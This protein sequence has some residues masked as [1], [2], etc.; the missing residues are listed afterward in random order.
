MLEFFRKLFVSDFMPHGH[1]YFW[2]PYLVWLNTTSDALVGLSYFLIPF[3]LYQIVRKRRDLTFNWMILMFVG[4]ILA[5]GFTHV[6]NVWDVWHSAYRLEGLVKA[7]TAAA[8]LATAMLMFRLV[9]QLVAIP[10]S[11]QLRHEIDDRKKA[12]SEVRTLNYELERRVADRTAM[13]QR[14]NDA[15]QRFAYIVS[16]DLQEPVRTIRTMNQLLVRDYAGKLDG[17]ADKYISFV[18]DASARMQTLISDLLEYACLMPEMEVGEIHSTDSKAIFEAVVRNLSQ[19]IAECSAEVRC[20]ELPQLAVEPVHLTQV[21]QNLLSNSIKYRGAQK[22]LIQVS[23]ETR[24][25]E[26]LFTFRDNGIGFDP[27][28]SEQIF[29]AFR[30]L[31]GREFPGSGVGLSICKTIVETYGGRIW[32]RS[33]PGEGTSF[34]FTLPLATAIARLQDTRHGGLNVC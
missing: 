21:F 7:I 16:H 34:F 30:R 19:A 18:V 20:E 31:H 9:P 1:C 4:F 29:V 6:M 26:C 22:P 5:C 15:L 14:S 12:E 2:Q 25:P 11:Q 32:V 17:K 3:S 27:E 28:Y 8:S 24:G 33:N 13:L 10:S 23:A